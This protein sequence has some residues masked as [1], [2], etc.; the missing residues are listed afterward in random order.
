MGKDMA[1]RK[2]NFECAKQGI[3]RFSQDIPKDLT[4][5]RVDEDGW[6]F[7]WNDHSVTGKELN[8][9]IGKV[10]LRFA[11][12]N[13]NLRRITREFLDV[14]KALD[15]LDKEYINGILV[16]I[17]EAKESSEQAKEASDQAKEASDQA[18]KASNQAIKAQ[19]DN[20]ETLKRLNKAVLKLQGLTQQLQE[21][22]VE[23]TERLRKLEKSD[24]QES[25]KEAVKQDIPVSSDALDNS[26]YEEKSKQL[27]T[28][29][30]IAY[31][32]AGCSMLITLIQ[33]LITLLG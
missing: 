4:I 14:Y 20:S 32:L 30:K 2:H 18:T 29:I 8:D 31:G 28:K 22:K 26:I 16:S 25:I 19:E 6:F 5:D 23:A 21:F 15:F 24:A 7:G 11:V 12:H 3:R 17:N 33:L 27:E 9:V 13:E 10:Q 1:I